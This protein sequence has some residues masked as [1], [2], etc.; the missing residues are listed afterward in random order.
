MNCDYGIP[1]LREDR[2]S[3]LLPTTTY[4]GEPVSEG[5]RA[6]FIYRSAALAKAKNCIVAF[7]RD[8]AILEPL[9]RAPRRYIDRFLRYG[10]AALVECD[11]SL[12]RDA[13]QRVQI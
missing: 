7:Y 6:L 9:W 4:G 12:W 8:D 5:E 2:L 1:S 13:P 10:V 3:S 11:F